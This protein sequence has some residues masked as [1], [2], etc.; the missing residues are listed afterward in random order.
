MLEVHSKVSAA[1]ANHMCSSSEWHLIRV[2]TCMTTAP[3]CF[4][5]SALFRKVETAQLSSLG[6]WCRASGARPV[7]GGSWASS[8][9]QDYRPPTAST[10]DTNLGC[11]LLGSQGKT[12]SR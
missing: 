6:E 1:E 8:A 4:L 5:P 10:S 9:C 3:C 12:W 7:V 2:Y 11:D